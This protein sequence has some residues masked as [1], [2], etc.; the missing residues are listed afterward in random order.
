MSAIHGEEFQ[1][2]TQG[3]DP[4]LL[5]AQQMEYIAEFLAAKAGERAETALD[6]M[7]AQQPIQTGARS[8]KQ[9]GSR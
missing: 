7:R 3:R 5:Y 6:A 2:P 4:E 1:F 8:G 9:K